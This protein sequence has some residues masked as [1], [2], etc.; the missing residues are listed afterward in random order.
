MQVSYKSTLTQEVVI[1][2]KKIQKHTR[3]LPVST[4]ST[5]QDDILIALSIIP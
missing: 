4:D 1:K 2:K 5:P 3:I